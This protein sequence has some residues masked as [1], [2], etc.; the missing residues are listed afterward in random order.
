[1]WA[2][3]ISKRHLEFALTSHLSEAQIEQLRRDARRLSRAECIPLSA[4]QD[5]LAQ[6]AGARNWSLLV[7]GTTAKA[8]EP[9]R[10]SRYDRYYL[11]GDQDELDPARYYCAECD[12]FFEAAHFEEPHRVDHGARALDAVERHGRPGRVVPERFRPTDAPNLFAQAMAAERAKRQAREAA[13]SG[14]HRWLETQK[15]R[16]DV[17]GDL[18][19]DI[20]GDKSFPAAAST[21]LQV[22]RYFARRYVGQHVIDA[23]RDAWRQYSTTTPYPPR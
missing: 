3:R 11:H 9:V 14:F 2:H 10:A 1:V 17:V 20:L 8:R 12:V 16:D 4:V 5:R 18:A 23:L 21:Y 15:A 22:R 19:T 6:A 7:K 13:N